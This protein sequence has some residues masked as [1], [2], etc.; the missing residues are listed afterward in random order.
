M[1]R[2][3]PLCPDHV[4][5][6]RGNQAT[7]T[8]PGAF[9]GAA[10]AAA[11][12]TCTIYTNKQLPAYSLTSS[13]I[14]VPT[15]H[16]EALYAVATVAAAGSGQAA[17]KEPYADA[18]RNLRA[19]TGEGLNLQL[20]YALNGSMAAGHAAVSLYSNISDASST[21][22]FFI[23]DI[24][25]RLK[26]DGAHTLP[27]TMELR[28]V[29]GLWYLNVQYDASE[30]V[31]AEHAD[32]LVRLQAPPAAAAAARAVAARAA[33][34]RLAAPGQAGRSTHA[35]DRAPPQP[36]YPLPDPELDGDERP[37]PPL[38]PHFRPERLLATYGVL[39]LCGDEA[40]QLFS[41]F[42]GIK[43]KHG[44]QKQVYTR[45]CKL[46][47]SVQKQMLR[48][49]VSR[50][51]GGVVQ[52]IKVSGFNAFKEWVLDSFK[53][54]QLLCLCWSRKAGGRLL[55]RALPPAA[56]ASQG[57]PQPQPGHAARAVG[58]IPLAAS[59]RLP[60]EVPSA[61]PAARQ[62]SMHASSASSSGHATSSSAGSGGEEAGDVA[63]W[64]A[65]VRP[66]GTAAAFPG[67]MPLR[68]PHTGAGSRAGGSRPQHARRRR[69]PSDAGEAGAGSADSPEAMPPL[70]KRPRLED[71]GA[72]RLVPQRPAAGSLLGPVPSTG[73]EG[74]APAGN[75]PAMPRGGV[76]GGH[77]V[78]RAAQTVT[79]S[80]G[81][82][83]MAA[84]LEQQGG[85]SQ[86][87]GTISERP[88]AAFNGALANLAALANASNNGTTNDDGDDGLPDG[89]VLEVLDDVLAAL[90]SLTKKSIYWDKDPLNGAAALRLEPF[91][92]VQA[93]VISGLK[94]IRELLEEG[95]AIAALWQSYDPAA[96]STSTA[97]APPKWQQ[98]LEA[99]T[100]C[101][102]FIA[103]AE[104]DLQELQGRR[105][106]ILARGGA[107]E[108]GMAVQG[109]EDEGYKVLTLQGQARAVEKDLE[110]AMKQLRATHGS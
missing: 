10:A 87:R 89:D 5:G 69:S 25:P 78:L 92:Y 17:V 2:P 79:P 52:G 68:H 56:Q 100:L 95:G 90:E 61:R 21:T 49:T 58:L 44:E 16:M 97:R 3:V 45:E 70:Q 35:S 23:H 99:A 73:D 96:P 43:L 26:A 41:R 65:S 33:G 1:Q 71:A 67:A 85:P 24:V 7:A 53:T 55:L 91:G 22:Q 31:A 39:H 66:L 110:A 54:K 20:R 62:P 93:R 30:A 50:V 107:A 34:R 63:G 104:R 8:G 13:K 4:G 88:S 75:E 98:L 15:R 81:Q 28:C 36:K 80:A 102:A 32:Q 108:N 11:T 77:A 106:R 12:G 27:L 40:E 64:L 51:R 59:M 6:P 18:V 14:I 76:T 42:T 72:R 94:R 60:R 74:G 105:R 29:A 46:S 38:F 37:C 84:R 86:D 57:G 103:N 9:G 82:V 83:G 101:G 19:T 48:I 109:A 47:G